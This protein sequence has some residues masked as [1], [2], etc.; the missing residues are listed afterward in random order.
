MKMKSFDNLQCFTLI[1]EIKF[2]FQI[3]GASF[4]GNF[5]E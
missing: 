2:N 5:K 3:N 4:S 1:I